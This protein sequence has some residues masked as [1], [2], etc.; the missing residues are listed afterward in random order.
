MGWWAALWF[1]AALS[2]AGAAVPARPSWEQ[3]YARATNT[4]G[5]V[6]LYKPALQDTQRLETVLAPFVLQSLAGQP[7]TEAAKIRHE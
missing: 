3:V 4:S 6:L 2:F 5:A 7:E 1:L